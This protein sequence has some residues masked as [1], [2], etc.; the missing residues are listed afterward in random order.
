MKTE[1]KYPKGF[2]AFI[3]TESLGAWNDN[4]FKMLIQLYAVTLL[5]LPDKEVLISKA[6]LVF[7][8]PFVI[9]GP[10]A[11][12]FADRYSKTR[13]MQVVKVFEILIMA[14]GVYAFY[15]ES[16]N[17]LIFIL[18]LMA[19]QSAFFSP[20]KSGFIPESCSEEMIT[21]ANG[22]MGMTTFV[23][24]IIGTAAGGILLVLL[25][26]QTLTASVIAVLIAAFGFISSLWITPTRPSGSSAK[27]PYNFVWGIIKDLTYIAK[28]KWLFLAA[29]ANSY[30]W[31]LALVFQTN[32]MVY[33]SEHLGLSMKENHLISLLPASMGIGIASGALLASRWSGRKVEIGLVPL[34]G[35]GLTLTGI[36]LFFSS[37]SYALTMTVLIL[38]GIAGGLFIIP[39]NSFLQFDAGDQ[40]KGRI[41]STTGI[42][43]GIFL[44]IGSF[45]YHLLA[46][47]MQFSPAEIAFTMGILTF[48][49]TVYICYMVPEYLLRFIAWLLTNTFYKITIKGIEN[50]P[51]QGGALL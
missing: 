1:K 2:G 17:L 29:L 43:N 19:A 40:E 24:I 15:A 5:A 20:A 12:F 51:F 22:I 6:V 21:G 38:G 37:S 26:N 16:I 9:F 28:N 39:L 18:F 31:L 50:I 27:F 3:L 23:S 36:F 4:Y 11:G 44:V 48:L 49:V 14:A 10:W 35:M 46:V 34:G 42:L 8:V 33:A 45:L 25:D 32:I 41:L 7:T 13:V 30:F 47:V